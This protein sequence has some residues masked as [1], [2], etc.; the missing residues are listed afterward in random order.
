MNIYIKI[1]TK[2]RDLEPRFLLGLTAAERGH[3]V[4]LG[5]AGLTT[6]LA[7]RRV[8]KPGIVHEKSITPAPL[9]V[10][11]LQSYVR[12]GFVCTSQDEESGLLEE[13]YQRFAEMRF[14]KETLDLTKKVFA[15]GEHDRNGLLKQYPEI[16]DLDEKVLATGSPRADMW[17]PEM[18]EFYKGTEIERKFG[19]YI[20]VVSNFTEVA[21]YNRT[22]QQIGFA[23]KSGYL[24]RGLDWQWMM[25]RAGYSY[26]L[27]G[28]FILGLLRVADENPEMNFVFRPHLVENPK[29]WEAIIED[30]PNISIVSRGSINR[31]VRNSE[32]VIHNGCTTGFEAA[33]SQVPVVSYKPITSVHDR[34]MSDRV[35]HQVFTE[36]ELSKVVNEVV[37]SNGSQNRPLVGDIRILQDRFSNFGGRLACDSIVDIWDTFKHDRLCQRNPTQIW[38]KNAL[39][40]QTRRRWAKFRSK[41]PLIDKAG[42]LVQGHKFDSLTSA[43]VFDLHHNFIETLNRFE[44]VKVRLHGEHLIQMSPRDEE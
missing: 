21:G 16:I 14:S 17:R 40:Y 33:I 11:E 44:R 4:F 23:R 3:S 15:W 28:L 35:S 7:A 12:N 39:V 25:S 34:P 26:E 36:D 42:A 24:N 1:E 43:E 32:L 6:H 31:W 18:K 22:W 27:A 20:L 38:R 29:A 19:R 8:L 9:R 30:R 41:L 10:A 37:T 13:E 5:P 2:N